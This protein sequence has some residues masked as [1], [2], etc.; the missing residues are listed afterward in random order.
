MYQLVLVIHVIVAIVLIG[1]ILLQRG[2]GADVGAAFGAGGGASQTVFG[3]QGSGSFLLRV[4]TVLGA[5]FFATSLGLGYIAAQHY[6]HGQQVKMP[7]PIE[8][9][10]NKSPA[11]Q[12]DSLS[13]PLSVLNSADKAQ[14]QDSNKPVIPK[15]GS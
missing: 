14:K 5:V 8:T 11:E 4:T 6:K 10:V 2:K 9:P 15:T 13:V 3:S 7:A 1:L 12:K